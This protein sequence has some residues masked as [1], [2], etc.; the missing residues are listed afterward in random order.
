MDGGEEGKG[1]EEI[2]FTLRIY[3]Y[4]YPAFQPS[5]D[6][7]LQYPNLLL[8]FLHI[9]VILYFEGLHK[10]DNCGIFFSSFIL[11]HYGYCHER[12]MGMM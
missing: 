11:M 4:H 3:L 10:I 8:G 9:I 12:E 2:L 7:F 6:F 1:K 5:T